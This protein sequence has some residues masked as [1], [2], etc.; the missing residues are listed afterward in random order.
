MIV[1]NK[2]IAKDIAENMMVQDDVITIDVVKDMMYYMRDI[3]ET[4]IK[5]L[6]TEVEILKGQ[7]KPIEEILTEDE[8][9]EY[10]KLDESFENSEEYELANFDDFLSTV[11]TDVVEN[12]KQTKTKEGK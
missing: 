6:D 7:S 5:S 2:D 8:L 11:L 9:A 12:L 10:N 1:T 4:K 3:Y